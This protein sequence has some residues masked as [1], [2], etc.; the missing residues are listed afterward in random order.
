MTV[1]ED[2]SQVTGAVPV[3]QSPGHPQ[4]TRLI[5]SDGNTAAQIEAERVK[6][7]GSQRA[8]SIRGIIDGMLD[9]AA[10]RRP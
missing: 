9:A 10:E 8:R 3:R 2:N 6:R 4:V 5:Q 1:R 7:E